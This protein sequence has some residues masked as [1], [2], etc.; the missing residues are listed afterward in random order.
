MH[1]YTKEGAGL[2][3]VVVVG[4]DEFDGGTCHEGWRGS[5]GAVEAAMEGQWK[6]Q[7]RGSGGGNGGAVEAA[8]EGQW[9]M[10]DGWRGGGRGIQGGGESMVAV[11]L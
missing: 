4:L 7:W 5:G 9:R 3:H 11:E 2:L 10:G 1:G 6:R 8:M